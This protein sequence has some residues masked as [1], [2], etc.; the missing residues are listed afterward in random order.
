MLIVGQ[1]IVG[2]WTQ[3]SLELLVGHEEVRIYNHLGLA[4]VVGR[5]RL[6]VALNITAEVLS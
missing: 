3:V 4:L 6:S 2:V 1:M 5:M